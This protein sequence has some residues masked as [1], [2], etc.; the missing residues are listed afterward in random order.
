MG[1]PS[2][3]S[4]PFPLAPT[5][6]LGSCPSFPS[7]FP[8]F[9][10]F[11]ML[12]PVQCRC[13]IPSFRLPLGSPMVLNLCAASILAGGSCS[14]C[15]GY[16]SSFRFLWFDSTFPLKPWITPSLFDNTGNPAIV[17]EWTFGQYQDPNV[18]L[19]ALTNHWDNW[20]T[21]ND[22]A[23]I[24]AAGCVGSGAAFGASSCYL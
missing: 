20:I 2:L 6:G 15:V 8:S 9:V 1:H 5:C 14:R 19:A 17:D 12:A 4:R 7:S 13:G 18:A 22:F 16:C 24:A 21:Q 10:L 11:L 23:T 3:L